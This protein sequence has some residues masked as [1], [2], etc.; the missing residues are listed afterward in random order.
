MEEDL[1]LKMLEMP[2][3]SCDVVIK[4]A[5]KKKKNVVDE[6]IKKV[7]ENQ[8]EETAVKE[9]EEKPEKQAVKRKI[10]KLNVK[11]FAKKINSKVVKSS[12][13]PKTKKVKPVESVTVKNT[14]FDI[15][16]VQVVAIFVLII[17]II[18]TN[19]F[20]EDSGMNNLLRQVFNKEETFSSAVYSSFSAYSPSKTDSVTLNEGV[21]VVSQ[22]ACYAP[23]NGVVENVSENNG[24]YT[25][26]VR[27][28]DSFTT[29]MSGL[30]YSY[31]QVG[32]NAYSNVPVGY[33]TGEITVSMF[34]ND[35]L[36]TAYGLNGNSIVWLT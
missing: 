1:Y 16:S 32:E 13:K 19:I 12:K 10:P 27:H 9:V 30:E 22:G 2:V 36:L 15:V 21:M 7:N 31:L 28:S 6:V 29:V 24:K 3:N 4:P 25:V 33:S 23:C 11:E 8:T 20:W 26:T 14:K 17:G 35:A 18:L 5:R 34:E